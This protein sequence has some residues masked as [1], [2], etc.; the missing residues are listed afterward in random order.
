MSGEPAQPM[1]EGLMLP[2]LFG[3]IAKNMWMSTEPP[4]AYIQKANWRSQSSHPWSAL[5]WAFTTESGWT[6]LLR[7]VNKCAFCSTWRRNDGGST[8]NYFFFR[9]PMQQ[10]IS[11]SSRG[12][13]WR[14]IIMLRIPGSGCSYA[15]WLRCYCA[16]EPNKAVAQLNP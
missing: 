5:L 13:F 16:L 15:R 4:R 9:F 1:K 14:W 2:G 12:I 11:V 6:T 7:M 10:N 8:F 3:L